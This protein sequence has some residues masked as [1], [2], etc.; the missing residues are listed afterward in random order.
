MRKAFTLIELLLVL[1]IIALLAAF[2]VSLKGCGRDNW[3][4]VG[5]SVNYG[6]RAYTVSAIVGYKG[7]PVSTTKYEICTTNIVLVDEAGRSLTVSE[8]LISK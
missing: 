3:V 6:G 7:S 1:T 4:S 5:D 2:V 8:T